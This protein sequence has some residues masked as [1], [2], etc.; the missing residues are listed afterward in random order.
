MTEPWRFIVYSGEALQQFAQQQADLYKANTPAENFKEVT[1]QN[2]RTNCEKVSHNIV[3]YMKRG[4]NPNIPALE[5]VCATACAVE[6]LLLGASEA[7]LAALW[8]TGGVTLKPAFKEFL[9]L[10]P[11]DQVLGQ[12]YL[13]YSD[14]VKEGTRKVPLTEKVKWMR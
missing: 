12:I 3:A 13:G 9:E 6:N 2:I 8:S 10:G 7:G 1:Y 4:N 5:E 11:D 14:S